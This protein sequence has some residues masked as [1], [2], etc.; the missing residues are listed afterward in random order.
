M[1]FEEVRKRFFDTAVADILR[2]INGGSLVGCYS[3]AVCTV[4]YLVFFQDPDPSNKNMNH[5]DKYEAFLK[6][7]FP[8]YPAD[9]IYALRCALVHVYGKSDRMDKTTPK[10]ERY[11][12]T[13]LN[14]SNHLAQS[15]NELRLNLEDFITDVI[16]VTWEFFNCGESD[17]TLKGQIESRADD[18][19]Q[20]IPMPP[21][22]MLTRSYGSFHDTLEVFD[23]PNPTKEAYREKLFSRLRSRTGSVD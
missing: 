4:D 7:W 1:Q 16:F 10:L 11:R 2:A 8:N 15:R 22:S 9:W 20:V 6:E 3:L 13:H 12:L 14:P 21:S 23:S 18:M 19:L 17:S 5:R